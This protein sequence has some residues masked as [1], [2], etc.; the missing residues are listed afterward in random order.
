LRRVGWLSGWR[1]YSS[2]IILR[3]LDTTKQRGA[4]GTVALP[5]SRFLFLPQPHPWPA[6]ILGDELDAG[7]FENFANKIE[8]E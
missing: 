1:S 2:G 7:R 6:A 3:R 4:R 5:F 8:I